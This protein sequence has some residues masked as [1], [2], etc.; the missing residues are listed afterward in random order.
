VI[1]TTAR[2]FVTAAG[3]LVNKRRVPLRD[4]AQ[5]EKSSLGLELIQKVESLQGILLV[6]RFK[7]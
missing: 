4:P 2:Y 6:P 3:N 7:I 1:E 5:H